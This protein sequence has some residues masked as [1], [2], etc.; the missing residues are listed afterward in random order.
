MFSAHLQYDRANALTTAQ[1]LFFLSLAF[2][3]SA[4]SAFFFFTEEQIAIFFS[5]LTSEA[6]FFLTIG[7]QISW[8]ASEP[9]LFHCILNRIICGE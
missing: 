6:T 2:V 4:Q 9:D 7:L 8:I 1:F 3:I 5:A